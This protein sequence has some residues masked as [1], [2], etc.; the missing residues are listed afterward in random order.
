MG[1]GHGAGLAH[2]LGFPRIGAQRELPLAMEAFWRGDMDEAALRSTAQQLRAQ[3]WQ[4]QAAAGLDLVCVGDFAWYDHVLGTLA[5]LGAWPR[6]FQVPA[7]ALGLQDYYLMAR[8]NA[9]HAAMQS[10][11][12]FD[13]SYHYLVPEWQPDTAF[14]HGVDWLFEELA[15]AQAQGY[16]AKVVLLGPLSLLYLGQTGAGLAQALALLP[17]ALAAYRRVLARLREQGVELVQIE[18]PILALE[19]AT[20]WLQAF[21]TAYRELAEAAPPLLLTTCFGSVSEHVGWLRNLPVAGVHVDGVRDAAQLQE[22]AAQW[23]HD[24]VLS[25]GIVDGRNIWRCDLDAALALLLPLQEQLGERLWLG[26]SCSLLH[27]P[28]DLASEPALDAELKSWLAFARQKLDEVVLL[29]QALS[30]QQEAVAGQFAAARAALAQRRQSPRI[31]NAVVQQR[32]QRVAPEE[33]RRPA[34]LERQAHRDCSSAPTTISA[35]PQ[36]PQ[37]HAVRAAYQQGTIGHLDYLLKMRDEIRHLVQQQEQMGLEVVM[38]GEPERHDRVEYFAQQLWGYGVTTNGWVQSLGA[39][40]VKP[41]FIYGD[42]YRPE[43][44]TVG[45][46][47]FAQSLTARPVKGRLTGPLTML[48]WSFVR[49]DQ[50][51]ASTALQLA[52]AVHE[53]AS[54]LEKAGIGM[55]QIDEP[56]FGAALP[57]KQRDWPAHF[58]W[59]L[60]ALH[61]CATGVR[62][63]T[64]IHLHLCES[65]RQDVLPWIGKIDADVITISNGSCSL[66]DWHGNVLADSRFR[67]TQNGLDGTGLADDFLQIPV[68]QH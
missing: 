11:T 45:W 20:P 13:T 66:R 5:L 46:S 7:Q 9:Q 43:P 4:A 31:R 41:P 51:R 18:E 28:V 23:P 42:I 2:V 38:H 15:E 1:L 17:R 44:M 19:L 39:L 58:D 61:C 32:M 64:S 63:E 47:Q 34:L 10:A 35:L 56:A 3:H 49:D 26:T 12:W 55:I 29:K 67:L 30:G 16:R 62:D 21:A 22:F 37:L 50:P 60:H 25:V 57:L 24:K 33:R 36:T 6:R 54:D 8:G 52:L 40:C 59:V 14:E 68:Q 27:V 53:E 65:G 48:Q